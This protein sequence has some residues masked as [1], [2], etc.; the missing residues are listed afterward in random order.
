M[1]LTIHVVVDNLSDAALDRT[2]L[3]LMRTNQRVVNIAAGSQIDR[4]FGFIARVRNALPNIDIIWR[5]LEDTG[6]HRVMSV[7]EW[8]NQRIAPH[9]AF[10]KQYRVIIMPDNE[11]SGDDNIIRY[12]VS[13][14][15]EVLKR[16]HAEG[17]RG[18][19]CRFATG[20]IQDGAHD[21]YPLLKPLL[22]ALNP[23]DYVSPNEYS[24][25][26]GKSSGGHLKRWENFERVAGRQ[27]NITIGEAGIANDYN[28]DSGY[29]DT[30]TDAAFVNQMLAE[31]IWYRDGDIDRALYL[32]GG[33]GWESFQISDKVLE[34]LEEYYAANPIRPRKVV[35]P[36][37][38][39]GPTDDTLITKAVWLD[40]AFNF[41]HTP[42][43]EASNLIRSYPANRHAALLHITVP[44]VLADGYSWRKYTVEGVDGWIADGIVIVSD[45]VDVPD[46]EHY[47]TDAQVKKLYADLAMMTVAYDNIRQTLSNMFPK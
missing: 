34:L 38:G 17:L 46:A 12:Y 42:R 39:P 9:L 23:D 31:E 24:N 4:G 5:Q 20:N 2:L 33:Y 6:I 43:R 40:G 1:A 3:Y 7:D 27:L 28:P 13:W 45:R 44:A 35:T 19:M 32:R 21:Q 16:L 22:D 36:P 29:R 25:T 14:Q 18:A 41:R 30:L 11:S 37:T 15:L 26:P 8:W 10:F 47:V